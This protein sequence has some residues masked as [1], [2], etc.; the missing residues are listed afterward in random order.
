MSYNKVVYNNKKSINLYDF[1]LAEYL[2]NKYKIPV[3]SKILDVGC[4][5]GFM[6][7]A[8]IVN[9]MY[10]YALDKENLDVKCD[11]FAKCD[12]SRES[13]PYKPNTFDVVFCKSVIEHLYIPDNL[14]KEIYR[15]LKPDGRVIFLTPEWSSQTY[16]FYNDYTHV[17]PYTTEAIS[18][19]LKI[20]NF[21]DVE[22][23][24]FIQLPGTWKHKL[25]KFISKSIRLCLPRP[26]KIIK[27]KWIRWSCE[28]QILASA[29]K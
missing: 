24:S 7:S 15:V 26:K 9:D 12:I 20:Y 4:G 5:K 2:I 19:L 10:V 29:I 8:F 27:N 16:I 21:K 28:T 25:L 14:M 1:K 22:S 18:D 11:G 13:I 17:K 6:T 23:E 3:Y